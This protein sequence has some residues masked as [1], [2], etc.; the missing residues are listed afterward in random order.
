[1]PRQYTP[2]VER[3][4][5]NC[6][7]GFFVTASQAAARPR[8]YCSYG[9]RDALN[10]RRRIQNG[11]MYVLVADD[12]YVPEHRLVAEHHLGRPLQ[13]NE[14]VHH[15]PGGKL[16]NRWENLTVM[17]KSEHAKLHHAERR[18]ARWSREHDCC[19]VCGRTDRKHQ[20]K[21]IC[22]AC[23]KR[24][25]YQKSSPT[26]GQPKR[27]PR[28]EDH[29][30]T[31][32]TAEQVREIRLAQATGTMSQRQLAVRYGVAKTTIGRIVRREVWGHVSD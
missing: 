6:G 23:T 21:G 20:G 22:T 17:S 3:I 2:R 28:G 26:F 15:G 25:Q 13:P 27:M 7:N 18:A 30:N 24:R 29:A 19:I 11:Y 10:P 4:C 8:R 14:D 31:S 9:C 32:L 16:D 5:E 12:H 1:M